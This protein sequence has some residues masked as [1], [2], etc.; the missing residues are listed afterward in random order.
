LPSALNAALLAISPFEVLRIDDILFLRCF[1]GLS[2]NNL[3]G[4]FEGDEDEA[5][6]TA[7]AGLSVWLEADI[8][9]F[10]GLPSCSGAVASGTAGT[11]TDFEWP[12]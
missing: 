1:R 7:V 9:F 2:R 11:D 12:R 8:V 10:K 3:E 6:S 4:D 5:T